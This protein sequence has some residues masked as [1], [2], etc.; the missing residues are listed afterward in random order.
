MGSRVWF[1]RQF[2][3]SLI[4]QEK[5]LNN[6]YAIYLIGYCFILIQIYSGAA[7]ELDVL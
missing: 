2:C 1:V 3:R 4:Q 6:L 7:T 5:R